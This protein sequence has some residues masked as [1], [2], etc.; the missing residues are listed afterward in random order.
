MESETDKK[1]RSFYFFQSSSHAFHNNSYHIVFSTKFRKKIIGPVLTK[2]LK[3]IYQR[4]SLDK[5]ESM[6]IICVGIEVDHVHVLVKIP[7]KM[8]VSK[9]VQRIKGVASRKIFQKYPELE[10]R[11]GKRALWQSGYFSRSLGEMNLPQIKT[12]L[13]KQEEDYYYGPE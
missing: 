13:G 11:I 7:P 5:P 2:E 12:Y 1:S 10:K 9:A 6:E 4:M 8:A 3:E